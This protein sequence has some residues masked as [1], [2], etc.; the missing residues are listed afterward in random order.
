MA[1]ESDVTPAFLQAGLQVFITS[2]FLFLYS[3]IVAEYKANIFMDD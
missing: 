2:V 3:I 1:L